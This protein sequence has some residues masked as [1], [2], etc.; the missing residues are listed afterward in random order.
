MPSPIDSGADHMTGAELATWR[1]FA[2]LSREDLAHL[3]GVQP[4]TVKHWES[5]RAGVPADVQAIAQQAAYA[6]RTAAAHALRVIDQQARAAAPAA[7]RTM[8]LS[9][10]PDSTAH[11]TPGATPG[12]VVLMRYRTDED[13]HRH[14]PDMRGMPCGMHGAI[15]REVCAGLARRALPYP[16]GTAPANPPPRPRVVWMDSASYAA[17]LARQ[18][19]RPADTET[20]RAQWAAE[21]AFPFQAQPH[22]A[23]QPPA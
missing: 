7:G 19:G 23:D 1:E 9:S 22:R 15:V 2:G 6:V 17:W 21:Q 12:D 4:R 5:G 20:T 16:D 13:L 11:A 8:P 3:A 18:P 10:Q 14:R